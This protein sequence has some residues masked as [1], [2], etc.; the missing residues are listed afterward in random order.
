MNTTVG[1][2]MLL[3]VWAA[4]YADEISYGFSVHM[5]LAKFI[6]VNYHKKIRSIFK[7]VSMGYW[8]LCS[9]WCYW[10]AA[11]VHSLWIHGPGS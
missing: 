1:V 10:L 7:S 3:S 2:H 6:P 11:V 8:V 4:S 5:R 9:I